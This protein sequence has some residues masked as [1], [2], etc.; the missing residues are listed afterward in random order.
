MDDALHDRV[1]RI[2]R[3]ILRERFVSIEDQADAMAAAMITELGLRL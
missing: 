3:E 2:A 1:A